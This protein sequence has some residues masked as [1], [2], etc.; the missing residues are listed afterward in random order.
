METKKSLTPEKMKAR[1]E[2][3][4]EMSDIWDENDAVVQAYLKGCISTAK[5]LAGKEE[6]KKAG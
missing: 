4:E 3:A 1:I 2:Q 6:D 5:A